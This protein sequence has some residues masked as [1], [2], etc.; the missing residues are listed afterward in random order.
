MLAPDVGKLYPQYVAEKYINVPEF[1]IKGNLRVEERELAQGT[2]DILEDKF[3]EAQE[4]ILVVEDRQWKIM[5]DATVGIDN[6][7]QIIAGG[8]TPDSLA[9]MRD[10]VMRWGLSTV[11]LLMANDIVVDL[12]GT[13]FGSW[14]D[15]I[16][17]AEIVMTGMLGTLMGLAFITDAYRDPTLRV[18]NQGDLYILTTPEYHGAYTDRGPVSSTAVDNYAD[19]EPSRGW[20]MF[21]LVSMCIHNTRSVVKATVSR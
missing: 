18:L 11:T 1:Y 6:Q 5:V 16:S 10:Q 12:N 3:L 9:V 14:F 21:E 17:Q 4:Q 8:L 2:G 15:P 7:L 20:S 19:G 13:T